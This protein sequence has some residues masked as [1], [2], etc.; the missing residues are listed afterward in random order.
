VIEELGALDAGDQ[1]G[2]RGGQSTDSTAPA[3]ATTYT[4][5][6]YE[7]EFPINAIGVK[8][9][10]ERL[11][12]IHDVKLVLEAGDQ[13]ITREMSGLEDDLKEPLPDGQWVSRPVVVEQ[14]DRFS[15]SITLEPVDGQQPQID[16]VELIYLDS[17]RSAGAFGAASSSTTSLDGTGVK[18]ISRAE[19][20]ADESL[21]LDS[22][23]E[24][25]W[26]TQY[27]DPK[28]FIVHHTAGTDGGEDPAA[29]IRAIYY[30]HTKVLGWGDIGYN[31]L[32]DRHGNIYKGRVGKNGVIGGHTYNSH[33]N[34]NYNPGSV[35]IALIGCFESTNGA[36]YDEQGV[37]PEMEAALAKLIGKKA[38]KNALKPKALVDFQGQ[39]TKRISGHRDW[40]YTYCPGSVVQDDMTVV[41]DK[42]DR[43][44]RRLSA[45]AYRGR[46]VNL[47]VTAAGS[48]PEE[49]P[50]DPAALEA[51]QT[52]VVKVV[53]KNTGRKNWNDTGTK[54]KVYDETGSASSPLAGA[55]WPD[56]LG[57]FPLTETQTSWQERG[58]FT[59]SFTAPDE[60]QQLVTTLKLF[61]GQNKVKNSDTTVTFTFQ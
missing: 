59:F 48:S 36:C 27:V 33:T 44:Y 34:T 3:G 1:T 16:R 9:F 24:P 57:K 40:D 58:P 38:A 26:P 10:G 55:G 60:P 30:W 21:R 29:T 47:V 13:T 50:L 18:I 4:A 7:P 14:P 51:G 17:S 20:G 52:Y 41:R 5:G 28:V 53:F 56:A 42:A 35:G 23:G 54:L 39:E 25:V 31:F 15:F 6:P 22:D 32:I 8:L 43:R 11:E 2:S 19:W 61:H 49:A 45:P 37:T 46:Q 12:G